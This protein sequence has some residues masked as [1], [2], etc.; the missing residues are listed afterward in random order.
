MQLINKQKV[1]VTAESLLNGINIHGLSTR[2][3]T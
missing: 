2:K 3:N 1:L